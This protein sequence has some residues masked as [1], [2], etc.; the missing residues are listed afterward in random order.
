MVTLAK[1]ATSSQSKML[2]IIEGAVLNAADAHNLPR[3]EFMARS[4]A[5]RAAGT[6]SAQWPIVLAANTRPPKSGMTADGKCRA[7]ERRKQTAT[8]RARWER[9]ILINGKKT[10]GTVHSLAAQGGGRQIVL[11]RLP[12]LELWGGLKREMWSVRRSND[13]AKFLA[14]VH[15][16]QMIDKLHRKLIAAE[17]P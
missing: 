3:D 15:L 4:I 5:K 8:S 11:R 10:R 9:V 6:L 16:L 7:C 17:L 1:R 2:K 14:Y 13:A 12:L